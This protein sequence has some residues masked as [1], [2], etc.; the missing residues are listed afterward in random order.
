M[1]SEGISTPV[2]TSRPVV[3]QIIINLDIMPAADANASSL[4]RQNPIVA[5]H[6][7]V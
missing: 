5:E 3:G 2:N 6:I 7:P 4:A 1:V